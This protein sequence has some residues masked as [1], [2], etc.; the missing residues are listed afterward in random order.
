MGVVTPISVA[1]AFAECSAVQGLA[2][3]REYAEPSLLPLYE[4]LSSRFNKMAH[5]VGSLFL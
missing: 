1:V 5:D 3:F 2:I 4:H